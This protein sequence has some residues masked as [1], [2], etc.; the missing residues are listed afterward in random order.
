M[1]PFGRDPIELV[2]WKETV[3]RA[4]EM[5]GEVEVLGEDDHAPWKEVA[6]L[7]LIQGGKEMGRLKGRVLGQPE[8]N[9]NAEEGYGYPW[10]GEMEKN[11]PFV[12]EMVKRMGWK[13]GMRSQRRTRLLDCCLNSA[14]PSLVV[15]RP[16]IH[17]SQSI[18]RVIG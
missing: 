15:K 7:I 8:V 3:A 12:R 14:E 13:V 1:I 9:E 5:E 2:K 10:E 16:V 11:G 6:T 4:L 18:I 17:V